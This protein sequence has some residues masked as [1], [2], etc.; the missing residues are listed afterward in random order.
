MKS[1]TINSQQFD[2]HWRGTLSDYVTAMP[3]GGAPL[4]LGRLKVR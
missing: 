2:L 4:T 3:N 1:S